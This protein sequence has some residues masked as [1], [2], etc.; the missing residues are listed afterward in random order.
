MDM[1]GYP[2][3][4]GDLGFEVVVAAMI[5]Q[6][7]SPYKV[8]AKLAELAAHKCINVESYD[9]LTAALDRWKKRHGYKPQAQRRLL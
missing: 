5:N 2:E 7:E 6:F 9:R 4:F 1:R 3:E 8:E